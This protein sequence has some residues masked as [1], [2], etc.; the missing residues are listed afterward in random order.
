MSGRTLVIAEAGVNHD[1]DVEKALELVRV[2]AAAGADIVKFQTFSA[3]LVCTPN[4]PKAAYQ[5]ETTGAGE[6][7]W[8]MIKRLELAAGDW[9]RLVAEC[10]RLG[11]EFLSTPFDEGAA[12]FLAALGVRRFK[13]PSGEITNLPF[14]RYLAGLGK[15]L[16]LSTGMADLAEVGAAVD[17]VRTSGNPPLTILHCVT[18]YPAPAADCNLRAMATMANTFGVPVGF[19]DHTLGR[20]VSLAAVALG[21]SVIEKHFTLNPNDE[22]PDHRASLA[23]DELRA[24]ISGIRAVEVALGDGIKRPVQSEFDNLA[25]A[26]KGLVTLA[27]VAEREVLTRENVAIRRPAYGLPPSELENVLGRRASRALRSGDPLTSADVAAD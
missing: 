16:I 8:A 4:A 1:G 11:I 6:S 21:A 18:A 27:D 17:A 10:A 15:P 5:V 14:V 12:D 22:G 9:P 24:F 7:Q 23:P 26:R 25:I 20:D 13:I 19:S 2:A 3:D